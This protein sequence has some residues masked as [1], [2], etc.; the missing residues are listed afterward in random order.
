M[1]QRGRIPF[2]TANLVTSITAIKANWGVIVYSFIFT[3]LAG[4]WSLIW[5]IA[6]VGVFDETYTCDDETGTCSDVN[7]GFLFLLFVSY[8]FAHQVLQVSKLLCK[9]GEDSQER[10]PNQEKREYVRVMLVQR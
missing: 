1:L 8:F 3:A 6:F 10:I 4:G 5:T 9:M 2:A 7:Y